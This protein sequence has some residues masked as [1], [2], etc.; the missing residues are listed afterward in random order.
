MTALT[1]CEEERMGAGRAVNIWSGRVNQIDPDM[2][3]AAM[4]L[5]L[6][7]IADVASSLSDALH[8]TGGLVQ[9][10]VGRDPRL[11][12]A[13]A[14]AFKAGDAIGTGGTWILKDLDQAGLRPD[15][16][17]SPLALAAAKA[18]KAMGRFADV[19]ESVSRPEGSD[20][21]VDALY[22]LTRT[23]MTSAHDLSLS[24][25]RFADRVAA[26]A[27]RLPGKARRTTGADAQLRS[28]GELLAETH[29][30][31]S[32]SCRDLSLEYNRRLHPP[33]PWASMREDWMP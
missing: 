6:R 11:A 27:R 32:A 7:A 28:A 5:P 2:P 24:M 19:L 12:L 9:A 30:A 23:E 1:G 21:D 29:K 8:R 22:K 33:D 31:A 3:L 26:A 14:R 25:G 15:V 17:T 18:A 13:S 4:V 10:A 20:S 16:R